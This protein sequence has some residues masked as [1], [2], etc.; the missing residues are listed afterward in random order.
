MNL[1][2]P[3]SAAPTSTQLVQRPTRIDPLHFNG[4]N[5]QQ[6]R[7]RSEADVR[8]IYDPASVTSYS[9]Q[10]RTPRGIEQALPGDTVVRYFVYPFVAA[11]EQFLRVFRPGNQSIAMLAAYDT[12]EYRSWNPET[13]FHETGN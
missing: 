6:V 7:E 1:S 9:L 11:P 10:V 8:V 3:S 5:P 13:G 4:H 12:P 2:V